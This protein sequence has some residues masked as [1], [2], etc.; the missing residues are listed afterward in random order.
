MS[1]KHVPSLLTVL[2]LITFQSETFLA[3]DKSHKNDQIEMGVKV[4]GYDELAPLM[5]LTSAPQIEVLIVRVMKLIKGK[6]QSD[7]IKVIYQHLHNQP[8]LPKEFFDSRHL[9]RFT[10]TR[11]SSD[12]LSCKGPL[13]R[14][15][16]ATGAE[17]EQL[18]GNTSLPCYILRPG[19]FRSYDIKK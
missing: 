10:L 17:T 18:P 4:V 14:L 9:W 13:P 1:I 19:G 7:Y 5:N 11:A 6:E 12:D 15:R 3:S 8:D 2:L 16:P